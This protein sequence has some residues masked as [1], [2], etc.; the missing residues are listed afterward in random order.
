MHPEGCVLRALLSYKCEVCS[1]KNF[2]V[3][4]YGDRIILSKS[5]VMT[6]TSSKFFFF[7]FHRPSWIFQDS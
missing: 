5:P 2:A 4:I 6:Y 1:S 7:F 3:E